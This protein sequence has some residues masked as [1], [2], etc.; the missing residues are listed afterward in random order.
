MRRASLLFVILIAACSAS[1]PAPSA[2]NNLTSASSQAPATVEPSL[3]GSWRILAI[4]GRAPVATAYGNPAALVIDANGHGGN[5]GCNDFGGYGLQHE[6]RWYGG[7]SMANQMACG[8]PRDKQDAAVMGMLASGPSL[9]WNGPD[10]VTLMTAK[11]SL[12]LE[13]SGPARATGS[14]DAPRPLLGTRWRFRTVDGNYLSPRDFRQAPQMIVEGERYRI[15]T[16]C[17]TA[18]GPWRQTGEGQARLEAPVAT[19]TRTCSAVA[20]TDARALLAAMPGDKR[21]VTGP[22]GEIILAGGGH[23][24]EGDGVRVGAAEPGLVVGRWRREGGAGPDHR[25]GARPPELILTERGFGLWNGCN[26]TEGLAILFERQLIIRGS[27][28]STLVNCLPER[29]DQQFASVIGSQPRV[30]LLANGGLLLSSPVGELR[31]RKVGSVDPRMGGVRRTLGHP[32]RFALLGHGGGTLELTGPTRFRLTLACGVT[33]GSWRGHPRD[34]EGGYRF[35]PER[36]PEAC[37]TAPASRPL[38]SL[39]RGDVEVAIGPNRDIAL[40][41]GRFGSVAARMER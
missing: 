14:T 11:Q 12:L 9:E 41:V 38:A 8:S 21:Y 5:A 29:V 34:S 7:G 23:W 20:Q 3:I 15:D 6:G 28:M 37:R 32:M 13:R 10:R 2:T 27:G 17:L 19:A 4:D 24:L 25:D 39:F 22:N 26:A 30:G 18:E 1:E 35:G 40:F 16:S 36:E 33:E 31:L